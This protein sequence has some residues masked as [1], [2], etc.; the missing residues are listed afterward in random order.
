MKKIRNS[1]FVLLTALTVTLS[2]CGGGGGGTPTAADLDGDGVPNAQDAFPNDPAKFASFAPPQELSGLTGSVFSTAV[3]INS[4]RQVVG[5]SDNGSQEMRAVLWNVATNGTPSAPAELNPL[6]GNTYSAAYAINDSGV[7]VGESSKGAAY[8][9]VLWPA[10][11]QTPTELPLGALTAP[12]AAY[13]INNGGRI[14]GEATTGGNTVPVY[15]SS[16]VTAAVP[17]PLLS[18][19]ATGT[20][21][22]IDATGTKIVG[23]SANSSG[24]MRAVLWTINSSGTVGTPTDLGVLSG[25]DRSVA[26]GINGSGYI[27]GESESATGEVHAVLW[28]EG[29]LGGLFGY[30]VTDLGSPGNG[31]SAAAINDLGFIAGWSTVS[32]SLASLWHAMNALALEDI[33]P[34]VSNQIFATTGFTQAYGINNAGIVVGL[35][36]DRAFVAMPQ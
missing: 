10:G 19:G 11:T 1:L 30:R 18:G 31:G 34:A 6:A 36:V 7:A 21:Y 12:S 13:G 15:W 20:A 28:T 22:F 14:V 4:S 5:M 33:S 2:G 17:L 35:S 23:E 25:H 9:A 8:V 27:V 32:G 24:K 16:S 29:I 26:F 3:S